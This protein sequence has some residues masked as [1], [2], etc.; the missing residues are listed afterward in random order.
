MKNLFLALVAVLAVSCGSSP[1]ATIESPNRNLDIQ[2]VDCT[3]VNGT[4]IIDLVVTNLAEE[5]K[6]VF[7]SY[8]GGEKATA[9]DDAGN[10]YP[11]DKRIALGVSSGKL[12]THYSTNNYPKDIAVKF[13]VEVS[14]VSEEATQLSLIKIPVRSY[15][16][17]DM[18]NNTYLQIKDVKW[19][20]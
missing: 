17:M 1:Q 2:F 12:T 13:R 20:K 4:V 18:G 11:R 15:G 9:Y 16:A 19:G 3:N 8:N 6:V 7:A 14:D 10:Q 5:E